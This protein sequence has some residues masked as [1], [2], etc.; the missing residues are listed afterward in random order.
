ML[1]R[2]WLIEADFTRSWDHSNVVLMRLELVAAELSD[3]DIDRLLDLP[4][5]DTYGNDQLAGMLPFL[6]YVR[7]CS[8]DIV[9]AKVNRRIEQEKSG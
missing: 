4:T 3:V 6:E 1:K 8:P 2:K 9:S 7:E 5:R